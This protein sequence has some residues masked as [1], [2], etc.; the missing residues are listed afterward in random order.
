[1]NFNLENI[2]RKNIYNLSPYSSARDE[3]KGKTGVFLDA[4]ENPYGH[5]NRYPDPCQSD[6]KIQLSEVK[7]VDTKNIFIGNGSDE[8][9]D[10]LYRIVCE[11]A[12]DK[13]LVF[14]PTY[15]MY[16]VSADINNV[17]LIKVPLND[18]FQIDT[19][20][21][22]ECLNDYVLKLIFICSPNNP[23]GNLMNKS[24]IRFILENFNGIVVIDEAYIDFSSQDSWN[25]E[26]NKYPNLVVCQTFS[27]A[28]GLAA[29]RVGI[30][31]ADE[32]IINLMNKVKPPYNVSLLNQKAALETLT[33]FDE[34]ELRKNLIMSQKN[35][36]IKLLE[37]LPLIKKIYPSDANFLLVEVPD[38]DKLYTDLIQKKI[39]TR[40]RHQLVR[41]CI[42]ITIGTPQENLKLIETLRKM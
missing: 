24:A 1:M 13:A 5:L 6:L 38:A 12:Q 21:V 26:I 20:K 23:T 41:N 22:K 32:A 40:N 37:E 3:F 9:I 36:L 16:K 10:L 7:K 17:E 15:S 11:P 33:N 25:Q 31:Y 19:E 42:R 8:A 4:N 18:D 34:F 28:W 30:A 27:K 29:A 39:I 14:P 35:K 2:V